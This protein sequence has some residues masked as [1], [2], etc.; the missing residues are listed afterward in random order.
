MIGINVLG[1]NKLGLVTNSTHFCDVLQK[2]CE[3]WTHH[4]VALH[5][6]RM[7]TCY[8]CDNGLDGQRDAHS[9]PAV[10]PRLRGESTGLPGACGAERSDTVTVSKSVVCYGRERQN[11]S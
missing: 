2:V 11:G 9:G 1:N 8:T 10:R 4:R 5:N 6:L 3:F 7:V